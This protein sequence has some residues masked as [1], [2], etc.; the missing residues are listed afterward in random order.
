MDGLLYVHFT[1]FSTYYDVLFTD[2]E[3]EF[4]QSSYNFIESSVVPFEICVQVASGALGRSLTFNLTTASDS[5]PTTFDGKLAM[6]LDDK[7]TKQSGISKCVG[8]TL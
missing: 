3:F 7:T 5:N 1:L 4:E 8:P 2:I 6:W